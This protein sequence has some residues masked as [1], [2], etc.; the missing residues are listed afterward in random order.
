MI[1]D[2]PL[3][4]GLCSVPGISPDSLSSFPAPGSAL[5]GRLFIRQPEA[6]KAEFL[7]IAGENHINFKNLKAMNKNRISITLLLAALFT[8]A[9]CQQAPTIYPGAVP[10]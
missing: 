3:P 1:P 8:G 5:T 2:S 7:Y 6:L 9:L 10:L 4:G